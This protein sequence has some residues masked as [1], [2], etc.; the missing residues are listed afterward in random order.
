MAFFALLVAASPLLTLASGSMLRASGG[1]QPQASGEVVTGLHIGAP[2][3]FQKMSYLLRTIQKYKAVAQ[4]RHTTLETRHQ[5]EEQRI[6]SAIEQAHAPGAKLALAQ[7]WTSNVQSLK[8]TERV[9]DNIE[10]FSESMASLLSSATSSGYGCEEL[11]CGEHA[12]CTTLS[13]GPQCVCKEGYMGL[14]GKDCRA[15]PEMRPYPLIVGFREVP[16]QAADMNIC[17]FGL[18][19]VAVVFRDVAQGHAGSV[20]V[21]S[22]RDAGLADLV[23]PVQFTS[24]K[25]YGPVV[26]GTDSGRIAIVWRDDSRMG[27]CWMRGAAVGEDLS[28]SWGDKQSFCTG[29]AHKMVAVPLPRDR[30]AVVFSDKA[31][32]TLHTP[33]EKFG[34]SV[35]ASVGEAGELALLGRFRFSDHPVMRLEV[36][37]IAP[38]AFVLA[39]RAGSA[40]D[41]LD[42]SMSTKQE[43]TAIY[44]EMID[45]DLVFNPNVVN[46]EPTKAQIWSRGVSLVAPNTIAYAYQDGADRAM[47]MAVLEV[48][49]LTHKMEVVQRPAVI[50]DGVSPYVSMLSAPYMAAHPHTLVY[51]ED[52]KANRSMVNLCTWSVA[53]KKLSQCE[54]FPWLDQRL[55]SVAGVHLGGGRSLLAF[56][57]EPAGEPYYAVFGLSK[58]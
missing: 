32:A 43:A 29:Q 41:D 11:T 46:I 9:F 57:A 40:V 12:S 35:L 53:D 39:A 45:D 1:G 20:V 37:K 2:T 30:L 14:E 44:A 17:V 33:A 22:V 7:T 27:S 48:D 50:H 49:P 47:K 42:P 55:R 28:L 38:M 31:K 26:T 19:K 18:N 54:D 21:G 58:K 51:Y 13:T 6:K 23:R 15:P 5:A 34:N 16:V 24:G 36:T 56:A 10:K 52:Q 4:D 3:E 8:D 25:A